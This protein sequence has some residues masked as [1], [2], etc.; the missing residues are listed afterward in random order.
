MDRSGY[1]GAPYMQFPRFGEVA[2]DGEGRG[3][4]SNFEA[5]YLQ[6]W[7]PEPHHVH[8]QISTQL[9]GKTNSDSFKE[10]GGSIRNS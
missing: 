4:G 9:P 1:G 7:K 6:N 2:G 8:T 5:Q 3:E 10:I